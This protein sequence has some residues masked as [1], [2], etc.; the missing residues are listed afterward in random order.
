MQENPIKGGVPHGTPPF[1][2]FHLLHFCHN[3]NKSTLNLNK[4]T[5]FNFGSMTFCSTFVPG[6]RKV[7]HYFY[8]VKR[9]GQRWGATQKE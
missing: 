5:F 4:S 9:Y 7:L 2:L 8:R 1:F 3:L 6:K